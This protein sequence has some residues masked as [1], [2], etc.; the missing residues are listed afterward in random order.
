MSLRIHKQLV[1]YIDKEVVRRNYADKARKTAFDNLQK[2]FSAMNV[3]I[4]DECRTNRQ[5]TTEQTMPD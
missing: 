5:D 4:V 1:E 2:L 3:T